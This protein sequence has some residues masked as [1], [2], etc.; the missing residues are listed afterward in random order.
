MGSSN[1]TER[2]TIV[3]SGFNSRIR[4]AD[5]TVLLLNPERQ[6]PLLLDKV[7]KETEKRGFIRNCK[8]KYMVVSKVTTRDTG[9]KLKM[10]KHVQ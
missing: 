7:A 1:D 9:Y 3:A 6:L 2:H 10:L 4:C 8:T 5:D